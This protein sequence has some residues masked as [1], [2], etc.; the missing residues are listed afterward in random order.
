MNSK[1]CHSVFQDEWLPSKKYKLWININII[2]II[3]VT[4]NK[5]TARCTLCQKEIDLLSMGSAALDLHGFSQ[6]HRTTMSDH[7]QEFDKIFLKKRQKSIS[8]R[9]TVS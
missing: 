6:K 8:E 4:E 7:K 9:V 1:K 2:Q 3:Q 5:R